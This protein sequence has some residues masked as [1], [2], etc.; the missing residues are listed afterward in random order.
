[1]SY[2]GFHLIMDCGGCDKALVTMPEHIKNFAKALV[3]KIDMVAYGEPQLVHFGHN[4]AK[5]AGYTLIQLIET[6]NITIHFVDETG[7]AYVDIFSCKDFNKE[8]AIEV[9]KDFFHPKTIKQHFLLRQA[10][11]TYAAENF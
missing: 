5:L 8:D 2:W 3:K 10:T 9:F 4:D 6:S 1:M 7:E 11:A